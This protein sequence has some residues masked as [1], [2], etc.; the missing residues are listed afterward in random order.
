[1]PTVRYLF[2]AYLRRFLAAAMANEL[3]FESGA[4][5]IICNISSYILEVFIKLEVRHY[6]APKCIFS[7]PASVS[8]PATTAM[9][10]GFVLVF[11]CLVALLILLLVCFVSCLEVVFNILAIPKLRPCIVFFL[12]RQLHHGPTLNQ[13]SCCTWWRL[14]FGLSLWWTW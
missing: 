4:A 12:H 9:L 7:S 3:I 13:G 11:C 6:S 2:D 10:F 1:M 8:W 5:F 14:I